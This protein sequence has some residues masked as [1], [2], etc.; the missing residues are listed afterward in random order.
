MH[1]RAGSRCLLPAGFH[2]PL[3]AGLLTQNQTAALPISFFREGRG[4][5]H[6]LE[7]PEKSEHDVLLVSVAALG[8]HARVCLPVRAL[9]MEKTGTGMWA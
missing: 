2:L 9:S 5:E 1:S 4:R 8:R 7:H 6:I 3:P